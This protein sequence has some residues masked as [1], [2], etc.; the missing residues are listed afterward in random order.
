VKLPRD[1]STP[2]PREERSRSGRDDDEKMGRQKS[3]D[4]VDNTVDKKRHSFG[5][6]Q[7]EEFGG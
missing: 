3:T 4:F 7:K 2:R 1:P 5:T 6:E